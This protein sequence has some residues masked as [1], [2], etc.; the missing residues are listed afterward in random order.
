MDPTFPYCLHVSVD[1][2]L[3]A[4]Q[5]RH[6]MTNGHHRTQSSR[7]LKAQEAVLEGAAD[8]DIPSSPATNQSNQ[9]K[10]RNMA[11]VLVCIVILFLI[12]QSLKIIPDIYEAIVCKGD[13]AKCAPSLTVEIIIS[14]SHLLLA[15]NS[16]ANFGIY[17]L[18]G[19]RFRT[20]LS[21]ILF[22]CQWTK[23]SR[24]NSPNNFAMTTIR[25][26]KSVNNRTILEV[27]KDQNHVSQVDDV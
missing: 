2:I 11:T 3:K 6:H 17:M 15:I 7:K 12:C 26:Q 10:E 4:S 23:A 19:D 21:K 18:R 5:E 25:R 16:A 13:T 14:I 27:T 8:E 24:R 22:R 20:V 9:K 1:R